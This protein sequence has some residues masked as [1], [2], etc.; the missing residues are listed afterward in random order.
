MNAQ[1][2]MIDT[3]YHLQKE[4]GC[5]VQ[6]YQTVTSAPDFTTGLASTTTKNIKVPAIALP[7]D[8][9]KEWFKRQAVY[10]YDE[11][12]RYFI[13]LANKIQP[14]WVNK[15]QYLGYNNNRYNIKSSNQVESIYYFV[16]ATTQEVQQP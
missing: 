9:A 15:G 8:I 16:C 7:L 1:S 14:F 2:F 13:I 12:E 3:I 5:M 4:Y 11:F 10:S 6:L